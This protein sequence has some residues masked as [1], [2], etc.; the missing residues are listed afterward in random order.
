MNAANILKRPTTTSALLILI[1][2]A[3][4]WTYCVL[5]H[6]TTCSNQ[7]QSKIQHLSLFWSCGLLIPTHTFSQSAFF[8][9]P[10]YVKMTCVPQLIRL[11]LG[12]VV[13]MTMAY[14]RRGTHPAC[15]TL[16]NR[17]WL[18]L[19]V[20]F[21]LH[22]SLPQMD[23]I[24]KMRETEGGFFLYVTAASACRQSCWLRLISLRSSR[25]TLS[26]VR[27]TSFAQSGPVQVAP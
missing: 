9:L 21:H 20:S 18:W 19:K 22:P 15:F 12:F 23:V 2:V 11:F 4:L 1:T 5:S 13:S 17:F 24:C 25:I 14:E 7:H 27:N 26:R 16:E 10:S 6:L 3:F 8:Y